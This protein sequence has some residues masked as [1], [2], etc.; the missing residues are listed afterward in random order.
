MICYDL[1]RPFKEGDKYAIAAWKTEFQ[2]VFSS[3]RQRS[4]HT[5]NEEVV[6]SVKNMTGNILK[7]TIFENAEPDLINL[8]NLKYFA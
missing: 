7:I 6:Q 8:N 4:K 2:M 3:S 1:T 5:E